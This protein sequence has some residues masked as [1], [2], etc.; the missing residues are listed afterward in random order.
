LLTFKLKLKLGQRDFGVF[1]AGGG[2]YTHPVVALECFS[3]G[4]SANKVFLP[5][6][7]LKTP[8]RVF[9]EFK[10]FSSPGSRLE[11]SAHH[12]QG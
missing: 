1:P 9:R 4:V 2:G 8:F 11:K 12:K 10:K 3:G 5:T 7:F 6:G